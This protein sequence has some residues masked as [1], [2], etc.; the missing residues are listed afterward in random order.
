MKLAIHLVP[1]LPRLWIIRGRCINCR[2][3][4]GYPHSECVY[5][6][7]NPGPLVAGRLGRAPGGSGAPSGCGIVGVRLRTA[8]APRGLHRGGGVPQLDRQ[9]D[10]DLSKSG[11]WSRLTAASRQCRVCAVEP[12]VAEAPLPSTS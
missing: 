8:R 10:W 3:H 7:L 4:S 2:S 11:L 12:T 1:V 5:R 9:E 6:G